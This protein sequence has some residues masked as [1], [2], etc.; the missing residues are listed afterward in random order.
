MAIWG[1]TT[2]AA[3]NDDAYEFFETTTVIGGLD[4]D[5]WV[6][7]GRGGGYNYVGLRWQNVTIPQGATIDSVTID[8][9]TTYKNGAA[10][11]IPGIL[12]G[13]DADNAI[14]FVGVAGNEIS[15][16]TKTTANVSWAY[17]LGDVPGV[18]TS[19]DIKTIIQE[20]VNRG[21]WSSGNA[22]VI[23]WESTTNDPVEWA[24]A[25]DFNTGTA[26]KITIGYTVGGGGGIAV[27]RRRRM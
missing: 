15:G 5:G 6:C 17:P 24:Q 14:D 8:I 22:L 10:T 2:I 7:G 4:G 16:R 23:I 13:E 12:H 27:L 19:P 1:P 21:S 3:N 11:S 20:I 9:V 18:S 26:A 25:E